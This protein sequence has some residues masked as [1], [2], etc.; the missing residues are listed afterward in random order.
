[1]FCVLCH[2]IECSNIAFFNITFVPCLKLELG[3][4]D[5]CL[6]MCCYFL[7]PTTSNCE[8]H[9]DVRL[10]VDLKT[11]FSSVGFKQTSCSTP[12]V[13]NSR[14]INLVLLSFVNQNY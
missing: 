10:L 5:K 13:C 3:A 12:Y 11:L 9:Q 8:C 1:M 7:A 2:S 14:I 6:G 4:I